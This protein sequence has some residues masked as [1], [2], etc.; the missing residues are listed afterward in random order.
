MKLIDRP[1]KTLARAKPRRD[2]WKILEYLF[3]SYD[4]DF[5]PPDV[6]IVNKEEQLYRAE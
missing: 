3:S 2:M 4:F 6:K 1:T 5:L